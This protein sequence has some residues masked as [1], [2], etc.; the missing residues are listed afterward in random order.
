MPQSIATRVQSSPQSTDPADDASLVTRDEVDHLYREHAAH[1]RVTVRGLARG[2][3]DQIDDACSFAWLTLLRARP[4]RRSVFAWLV[5]VAVHEAW[6]LVRRDAQHA[7]LHVYADASFELEFASAPERD[8]LAPLHAREL[9]REV[10]ATLPD[11]KRHRVA[12]QALGFTY[13]EIG[14]LTDSTYTAVNRH[15]NEAHRL[16]DPLRE[17]FDA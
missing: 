1:L 11:R 7:P 6:R 17:P 13:R 15:L 2:S 12:L 14:E 16:L 3:E 5:T 4:R 9:L 10:A 8:L